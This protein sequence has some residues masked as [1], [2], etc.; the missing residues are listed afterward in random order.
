MQL[1]LQF[2]LQSLKLLGDIEYVI[3]QFFNRFSKRSSEIF[4]RSL[5]TP[6]AATVLSLRIVF[7]N[8]F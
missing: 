1:H 5:S 7:F 2:L 4:L 6:C 8:E 3:G